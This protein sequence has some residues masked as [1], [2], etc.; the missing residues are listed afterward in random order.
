MTGQV[1]DYSIQTNEGI[2]SG[3]DSQRY[4][5]AGADWPGASAPVRGTLVDFDIEDGNR[6]VSIYLVDA[7]APPATPVAQQPP[8]VAVPVAQQPP[9]VQP[10]P[11]P[12][13]YQQ[14]AAS[15]GKVRMT[16]ALLA[17]LLGGFGIHKFYLGESGAGIV[18]LILTIII[19][20]WPVS[21][22]LALIDAIKLF[23]MTDADFER[24]YNGGV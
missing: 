3:D 9:P 15:G 5:F 17:L 6:A 10:Y 16:A 22:V 18:R 4:R 11:T 14:P 7:V 24:Q 8:T 2:I 1:L 12:P 23:Q 21:A 20:T 13:T 19:I